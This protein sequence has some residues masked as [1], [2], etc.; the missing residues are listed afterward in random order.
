MTIP[1]RI[2]LVEDDAAVR[3]FITEFLTSQGFGVVEASNVD[4]ALRVLGAEGPFDLAVID[5]WLEKA[6]AIPIMDA[7]ASQAGRIP[8]VAISGGNETIDMEAIQAITDI[9]G[10]VT[11]LQKPF[12]KETLIDAV[13]AA[14]HA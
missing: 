9:S 7:I 3:E 6:T 14:L 12:A 2:L 10:A 5:F 13:T 11:F 8:V 4:T 1:K